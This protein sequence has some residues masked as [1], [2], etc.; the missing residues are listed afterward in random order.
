MI[1]IQVVRG[2]VLG[3]TGYPSPESMRPYKSRPSHLR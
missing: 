3:R 2:A 1:G